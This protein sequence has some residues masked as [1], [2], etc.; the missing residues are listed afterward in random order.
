M[1]KNA[2]KFHTKTNLWILKVG[3]ADNF[4]KV[5]CEG[6]IAIN[7]ITY[8]G[9]FKA[10]PEQFLN[11]PSYLCTLA[12][13]LMAAPRLGASLGAA[14]SPLMAVSGRWWSSSELSTSCG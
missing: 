9:Q 4:G 6:N 5:V 12:A 14:L 1:V 10:T 3:A 13:L 8:V 7:R 11:F 2:Y